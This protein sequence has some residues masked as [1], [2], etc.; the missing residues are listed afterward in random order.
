[1]SR[2]TLLFRPLH[3]GASDSLPTTHFA[4]F[5]KEI[6]VPGATLTQINQELQ[7]R[8]FPKAGTGAPIERWDLAKVQVKCPPDRIKWHLTQCGF[9][10]K[11]NP[12][13]RSY[14]Y[15][16]LPGALVI[17][18]AVRLRDLI[19]AWKDDVNWN[20]TVILSSARPLIPD[21]EGYEHCCRAINIDSAQEPVRASWDAMKPETEM[22]MMAW[23][24]ANT[25][26]NDL[27]YR[28]TNIIS[29]AMKPAAKEGGPEVRPTTEDT[30]K[31]WLD[32]NP[33]PGTILLS[34]GAPYGMAQGETF[35][36][37]VPAA[38]NVETFGH[39]APDNL[40]IEAFL[41]EVAGAVHSTLQT[42]GK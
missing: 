26:G 27:I 15:G 16:V 39:A 4:D 25:P 24:W 23:I 22:D 17:R 13:Y 1:M 31:Q 42:R 2:S 20:E 10:A 41:R 30:I 29:V 36:R 14:T 7:A 33:K 19:N 28:P 5:M 34:S 8:F 18:A 32:G 21:K 3:Q 12:G 9:I 11:T 35:Q 40:P 37:L 6:G 38:F